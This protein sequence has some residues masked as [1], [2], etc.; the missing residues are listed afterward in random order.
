MASTCYTEH[1]YILL[2][3]SSQFAAGAQNYRTVSR[4]C[5]LKSRRKENIIIKVY[6]RDIYGAVSYRQRAPMYFKEEVTIEISS[7]RKLVVSVMSNRFRSTCIV[8]SV[9]R[10]VLIKAHTVF[11]SH[12]VNIPDGVR[13][14]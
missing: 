9:Y 10:V 5:G 14:H 2:L 8:H 7:L 11:L 3:C 4:A 12:V 6:R 1:Y 13:L